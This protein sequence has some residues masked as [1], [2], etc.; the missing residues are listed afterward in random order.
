MK[1]ALR[2]SDLE[3]YRDK[4]IAAAARGLRR[5]NTTVSQYARLL[6]F[7]FS[8]V[9]KTIMQVEFRRRMAPVVIILAE[10]GVTQER[11]AQRIGTGRMVVR[12]IADECGIS[13]K[14]HSF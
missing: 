14:K 5:H 4:G 11:I 7:E 2:L 12:H 8:T 13:F 1:R 10:L 9:K 3:P 6:G